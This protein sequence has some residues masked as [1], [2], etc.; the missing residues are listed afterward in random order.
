VIRLTLA[1]V[2]KKNEPLSMFCAMPGRSQMLSRKEERK[3]IPEL[4]GMEQKLTIFN[5]YDK[6]EG[7]THTRTKSILRSAVLLR[8]EVISFC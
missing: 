2:G 4:K 6:L 8:Y 7:K 1:K 5:F 3:V